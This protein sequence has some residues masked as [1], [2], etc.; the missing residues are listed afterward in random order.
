MGYIMNIQFTLASVVRITLT[1]F[2]IVYVYLDTLSVALLLSLS[3][4]AFTL[5]AQGII[6]SYQSEINKTLAERTDPNKN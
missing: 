4:I 5:E 2:L 6:N 3:G 1:L